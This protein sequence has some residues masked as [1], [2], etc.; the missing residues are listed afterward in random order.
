MHVKQSMKY[1]VISLL[2]F[3]ANV[4]SDFEIASA[5]P[6]RVEMIMAEYVPSH[7]S[8]SAFVRSPWFAAGHPDAKICAFV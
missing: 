3:G 5:P 4:T 1:V 7:L 2:L 8:S 6:S